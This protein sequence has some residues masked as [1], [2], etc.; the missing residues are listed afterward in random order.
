[1]R[2]IRTPESD[3]LLKVLGVRCVAGYPPPP[4]IRAQY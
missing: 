3:A 1:V 4:A 2:R